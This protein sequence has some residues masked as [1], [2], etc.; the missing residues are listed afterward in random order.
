MKYIFDKNRSI[1]R[2]IPTNTKNDI[3]RKMNEKVVEDGHNEKQKDW[4]EPKERKP[5]S[6]EGKRTPFLEKTKSEKK[7]LLLLFI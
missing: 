7:I 5:K 6:T 4:N 3:F 1:L 2:R